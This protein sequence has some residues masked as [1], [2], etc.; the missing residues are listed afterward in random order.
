MERNKEYD[1]FID[2]VEAIL[3]CNPFEFPLTHQMTPGLY[4]RSAAM[5]AGMD[6]VSKIHKT[7]H[8]LWW[9]R[10]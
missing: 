6:G 9:Q 8:F 4:C 1:D 3:A 5:P 7:E 10:V 2:R